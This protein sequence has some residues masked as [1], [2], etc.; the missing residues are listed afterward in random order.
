MNMSRTPGPWPTPPYGQKLVFSFRAQERAF[1]AYVRTAIGMSAREV[2]KQE[3][4]DN[5]YLLRDLTY[6]EIQEV[7]EA[8]WDAALK[9]VE[10]RTPCEERTMAKNITIEALEEAR[11]ALYGAIEVLGQVANLP[12]ALELC[13]QAISLEL[14]GQTNPPQENTNG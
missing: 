11:A 9:E 13:E 8:G 4:D 10:R 5:E 14:C 2:R 3:R 12:H 7:W 1:R 6:S